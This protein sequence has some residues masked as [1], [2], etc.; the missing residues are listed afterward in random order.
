MAVKRLAHLPDWLIYAVALALLV[1]AADS[2]RRH[3]EAPAAPP[4]VPGEEAEPL[5]PLSP[6][7]GA[8][9]FKI[10]PGAGRVAT[11]FS[12]GEAG[13]WLT[14]QSAVR[15]CGRVAVIV[16]PGRGAQAK[17]TPVPGGALALLAT[18]GGSPPLPVAVGARLGEDSFVPGYPRGGAGEAAVRLLSQDD[19]RRG[20]SAQPEQAWVEIGRT[21]G[22]KG[23]D[24]MEGAPVID[25]LGRVEGVLL[26]QAPRR[27]R[28]YAAPV[29]AVRR[30]MALAGVAPVAQ[31][32][33]DPVT[34]D[35]YGR[36]ADV[37]RRDLRVAQVWC[38]A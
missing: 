7:N 8:K 6:F 2:R 29:A 5:S 20:R 12:I 28:L 33:G 14:A 22:L 35:N 1:A 30:A 23:L 21:D 19:P 11:A 9:I 17:A 10:A 15:G 4:P 38:G 31:P 25:G 32:D 27:G 3:A 26:G 16:A 34:T 36:A 24:G 37:L 13:V 18:D